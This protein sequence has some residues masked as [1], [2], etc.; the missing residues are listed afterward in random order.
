MD[1]F[2]QAMR[3]LYQ[4]LLLYVEAVDS[5]DKVMSLFDEAGRE[6]GSSPALLRDKL[7]YSS[8]LLR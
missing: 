6:C 4:Q 2:Q 5:D 7:F 1:T 8:R 3:R